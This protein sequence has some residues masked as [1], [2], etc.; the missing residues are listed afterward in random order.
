MTTINEDYILRM[1]GMAAA[2]IARML[3]L[4][5]EEREEEAL[6][7]LNAGIADILGPMQDIIERVDAAT[8]HTLLGDPRLSTAYAALLAHQAQ[9]EGEDDEKLLRRSLEIALEAGRS[10]QMPEILTDLLKWHGEH[11]NDRFLDPHYLQYYR[12]LS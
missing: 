9:F 11:A 7:V 5:V 6:E 3:G 12:D 2:V 10:G 8:A 4:K 1:V